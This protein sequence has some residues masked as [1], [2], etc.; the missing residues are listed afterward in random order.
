MTEIKENT[1]YEVLTPNGFQDFY[2]VKRNIAETIRIVFS[3]D[4]DLVC[5][6]SHRILC[7]DIFIEAKDLKI[8]S[9][10][11]ELVVVD[12]FTDESQ[13]V[14]DLLEVGNGNQYNTNN[15][16]SHNCSFVPQW[17]SFFTSVF[18][19]LTSG[20]DTKMLFTS[21][22]PK[23][24]MVFLE[25]GIHTIGEFV[26]ESKS[27]FYE[28]NN[29]KVQGHGK[30]REGN[31]F[32]NNG[33]AETRIF[34][35]SA[36]KVE[37]SLPHKFFVCKNGVYDWV[38][39]KDIEIGDYMIQVVG[40]NNFG[41]SWDVSSIEPTS[42]RDKNVF[43]L[44]EENKEHVAYFLGMLLSDGYV[45]EKDRCYQV[46]ITSCDDMSY[47]FDNIGVTFG[48]YDAVHYTAN[49]KTLVAFIKSLGIDINLKAP[50]KTIPKS[51]LTAPKNIQAKFIAGFMDGDGTT[52]IKNGNVRVGLSLSS[53]VMLNQIGMMLQNFGIFYNYYEG[54]TPG[55]ADKRVKVDSA[56]FR[57]EIVGS[58]SLHTYFSEIGFGLERKDK[59]KHSLQDYM[60]P[61]HVVPFSKKILRE[62]KAR[63]IWIPAHSRRGDHLS[64]KTLVELA[65]LVEKYNYFESDEIKFLFQ[66]LINRNI[67]F[68]PVKKI[69]ESSNEV[70]D[71]SLPEDSDDFFC[72][73]VIYNGILG[74]QT[75]CGINHYYDFWQGAVNGTNGFVPIKATW[76]RVPGR[77]EAWKQKILATMNNNME[78]F[79]QE[80]EG[81]F[82]GSS[83]TLISG[84][85]LKRMLS[86]KV[87]PISSAD[88]VSIYNK[89][90]DGH[91]YMLIADVSHGKGLDYSVFQVI[92]VSAPPYKQVCTYRSNTITPSDY[93][94]II[95]N[96]GKYY[97]NAFC[98]VENNDIGAQVTYQLWNEHNYDNVLSSQSNGRA[99]KK[100]VLGVP[101][102]SDI[103]IR[104]TVS[105]KSLGCSVLKLIVEQDQ[106]LIVDKETIGEL[107]TFSKKNSSYAAETDKNDD[108]VMPL[109]LFAWMTTT[110]LFK[111][112]T[113][114]NLVGGITDYTENQL[115]SSLLSVGVFN[116][117][118][119]DA[120]EKKYVRLGN[121]PSFWTMHDWNQ[122]GNQV[123]F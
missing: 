114:S 4:S 69:T 115:A 27:K 70:Y 92:D 53:E 15:V 68:V 30:L 57:L 111:E 74:H 54:I 24:T 76:E 42:N 85:C 102:K 40:H 109:V 62:G 118:V 71:F 43:K 6:Y 22:V 48:K 84:A 108:C 88:G 104:T 26:D 96:I 75:P 101:S 117:G 39:A 11:N 37:S 121:D 10:V 32:Y 12:I 25:D 21:C 103:G 19:T 46:T 83:G 91:V 59:F 122:Y 99:G 90:E 58:D 36:G 66:N 73:S 113:E 55:H 47:V 9:I 33:F 41:K 120:E 72:H 116:D 8:G 110:D 94:Q 100:L 18:P 38:E 44:T 49:S 95:N 87:V 65:P 16:V 31:L 82:I 34:Q 35:T 93:S 67:R 107:S 79:A 78:Q 14:Y 7:N 3:D 1:R 51:I 105:V 20:K 17:N 2:G 52:G 28:V 98:L 81:E 60:L 29:Y 63:N 112:I 106:L 86:G 5:T 61:D 50:K 89:K 80:F 123:V 97:N 13:Y 64:V 77:D 119:E 23:G 45:R 56:Y